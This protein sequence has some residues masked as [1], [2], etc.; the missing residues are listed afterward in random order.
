MTADGSGRI[1]GDVAREVRLV[2]LD[3]DGVLTDGGIYVA[4]GVEGRDFQLRRFHV[5]DGLAIHMLREAGVEAAVV[6][7]R[8]SPAV[9]ARARELRIAEVH[10]VRPDRKVAVVAELLAERDLGWEATSCLAD[11]LADAALLERVALPAAVADAA[12]EVRERAAWIGERPGGHAAVREFVEALLRAR[13]Q[14]D[15]LVESYVDAGRR[16][17]SVR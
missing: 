13:G 7:G 1:D 8:D 17:E 12:P 10:Q 9:R 6:S 11:D 5:R 16:G 3:A 14:W 2:V 4:D 15:D